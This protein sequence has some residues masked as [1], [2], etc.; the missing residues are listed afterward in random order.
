MKK[1][2]IISVILLVTVSSIFAQNMN[3]QR[4]KLLKTAF[5]TEAINLT[6]SEAEKFWPVY[7]LYSEKIQELNF[8]LEG[9]MLQDIQLAGGIENLSEVKAQKIIGQSLIYEK[10]ISDIKI[11]M[12]KE[13]SKIISAVQ[14]VKLQKSERDFKRRILQEYGRRRKGQQ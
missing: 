6:P 5:I 14:I 13:L 3:R 1:I 11:K 8:K 9:G 12:T 10:E 2:L 7:N 4:I